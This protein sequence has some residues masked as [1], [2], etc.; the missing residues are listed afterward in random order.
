MFINL[1]KTFLS[2]SLL[3]VLIISS[4]FFFPF[5]TGKAIFFRVTIEL[6]LLCFLLHLIFAKDSSQ[7]IQK[8]KSRLTNP[9]FISLTVFS[10]LFLLAALLGVNPDFSFWSNFERG[11]G[12]FQIIHYFLFFALLVLLFTKKEEILDLLKFNLGISLAVSLY[13]LLQLNNPFSKFLTIFGASP[14]VSGTLGNPS[15]LAAYLII[16]IALGLLLFLNIKKI[17]W[18]I[19]LAAILVFQ[20]L[21]IWQTQTRGAILGILVSL[22]VFLITNI[23]VLKKSIIPRF[24]LIIILIVL[25]SLPLILLLTKDA[26]FWKEFPKIL[27]FTNT[28]SLEQR[29]WT[30]ESAFIGFLERPILGWGA[31]NFP[32]VFDKYYNPKHYG[33]E[34]FFDRAHNIFL[35][36]LING[37]ILLLISYLAIF[38]FYYRLLF[39]L[40]I[41]QPADLSWSILFSLPIAYLVQ[42]FFLFEVLPIYLALFLFLVFFINYFIIASPIKYTNKF[43]LSIKNLFIGLIITFLI[44]LVLYSGSYLPLKKNLLIKKGF[45]ETAKTEDASAR[46]ENLYNALNF[47]SPVGLEE[48]SAAL[49]KSFH[50]YLGIMKK[51]KIIPTREVIDAFMKLANDHYDRYEQK[52][53]GIR[54]LYLN[55]FLNLDV[56]SLTQ[57][58]KYLERGKKLLEAG[59]KI[60]PTRIEIILPLLEIYKYENNK[61]AQKAL[62]EKMKFLRPDLPFRSSENQ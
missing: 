57:D 50:D 17:S 6:A 4:A 2:L 14:R 47:P 30:W 56:A 31:E 62:E 28:S 3:S 39:K 13:A 60:A 34:S 15:Y 61:Q 38:Y 25:I 18:K 42:G 10:G 7:E 16:A 48:A 46:L 43:D 52:F 33:I 37:G 19:I 24:Y 1:S 35:D 53:V 58:K 27:R 9:I 54:N 21:I 51:N 5:I 22:I 59:L 20:G 41:R 55:G 8:I 40:K 23:F 44:G 32:Y 12:A 11:E 26:N 29:F 36:Y 45:F 49:F